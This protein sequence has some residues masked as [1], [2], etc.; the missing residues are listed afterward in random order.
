MKNSQLTTVLKTFTKKECREFNKWLASPFFNQRQDVVKMF[1][2]LTA[3]R[4]LEEGKYLSKERIYKKLFPGEKFDDAKFRQ[5]AHFLFRQVEQFLAYKEIESDKFSHSIAF[6]KAMRK[7][8]LPSVFQ[9]KF[10]T[11]KKQ[12]LDGP[13]L[14]STALKHSFVVLEQYSSLLGSVYVHWQKFLQPYV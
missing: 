1:Q 4:H 7:R 8:K 3:S 14:D 2:Y 9:K 13:L 12:G 6:L 5:T 11:L 10:N